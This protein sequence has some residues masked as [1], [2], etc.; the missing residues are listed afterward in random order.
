LLRWEPAA[1]VALL[2]LSP[3]DRAEAV[4][5]LAGAAFGAGEGKADAVVGHL[6]EEL[7]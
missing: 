1:H 6:L 3:A 2:A 4:G 5:A 7:P